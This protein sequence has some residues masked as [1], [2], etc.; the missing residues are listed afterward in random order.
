MI[1]AR[2]PRALH[3]GVEVEHL[4]P[5]HHTVAGWRRVRIDQVGMLFLVAGMQLKNHLTRAEDPVVHV[6]MAVIRERVRCEQLAVPATAGSDIAHGDEGLS[7]D[8][9]GGI[10]HLRK[11]ARSPHA[12]CACLRCGYV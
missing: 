7:F 4:E 2:K 3:C 1:S 11:R 8:L 10:T 6:T 5:Q 12:C 9:P